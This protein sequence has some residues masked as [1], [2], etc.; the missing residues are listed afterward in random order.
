MVMQATNSRTTARK[1]AAFPSDR[2]LRRALVQSG[3]RPLAVERA[4]AHALRLPRWD[5]GGRR[6][7]RLHNLALQRLGMVQL[8]ETLAGIVTRHQHD[9]GTPV[10]LDDLSQGNYQEMLVDF[11]AGAIDSALNELVREGIVRRE[12]RDI[13]E[14]I[15]P[16]GKPFHAGSLAALR[17]VLEEIKLSLNVRYATEYDTG[18]TFRV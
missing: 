11:G 17:Q 12:K 16:T 15:R 13:V 10:S 7:R 5:F 9:T 6:R 8:K 2:E 14:V 4:M 1:A 3:M 18:R